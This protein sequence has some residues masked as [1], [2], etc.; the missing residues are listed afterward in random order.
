MTIVY[1]RTTE[2]AVKLCDGRNESN[3]LNVWLALLVDLMTRERRHPRVDP[4][5]FRSETKLGPT[6]QLAILQKQELVEDR[7]AIDPFCTAQNGIQY[8]VIH[9]QV[10]GE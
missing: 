6:N 5:S 2:Q 10:E 9:T 3:I 8:Q 7:F 1:R 4:I